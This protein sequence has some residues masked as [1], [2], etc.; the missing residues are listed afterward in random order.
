MESPYRTL[1]PLVCKGLVAVD[2][3]WNFNLVPM[4]LTP[5]EVEHIAA[6]AQLALTEEEVVSYQQQLSDILAYFQR[7]QMVNTEDLP[8]PT[9]G[10][11]VRDTLR[12]DQPSQGLD[13]GD[14][15]RNA[16]D[17]EDDQFRV[18]PVFG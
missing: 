5:E 4:L 14:T 10:P 15:T 12:L 8:L 17:I 16:A 9:G 18:P 6:L 2:K 13:K 11:M 3:A 1:Y 7:L